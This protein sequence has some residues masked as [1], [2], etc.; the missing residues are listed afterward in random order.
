MKW[1]SPVKL[2]AA[3]GKQEVNIFTQQIFSSEHVLIWATCLQSRLSLLKKQDAYI[4]VSIGCHGEVLYYFCR[5]VTVKFSKD[6]KDTGKAN[7]KKKITLYLYASN[8]V[9]ALVTIFRNIMRSCSDNQLLCLWCTSLLRVN[10]TYFMTVGP[11]WI[12]LPESSGWKEILS[13]SR[14]SQAMFCIPFVAW[15]HKIICLSNEIITLS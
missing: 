9:V 10:K 11:T 6:L 8:I 14:E 12:I 5:Q 13:L 15:R 4:H 3:Q 2:A 7:Q 1:R